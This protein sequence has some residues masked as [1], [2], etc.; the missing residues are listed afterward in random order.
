MKNFVMPG[1][2][3]TITA[4]AD[5]TSGELL[6]DGQIVGVISAD[7]KQG[8]AVAIGVEGVYELNKGVPAEA[9]LQGQP[10]EADASGNVGNAA[11][12]VVIGYAMQASPSGAP[13][14]RVKL[15]PRAA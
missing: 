8:E 9:F 1:N 11:G 5:V 13:T 4:P 3:L 10:V 14:V 12:T 6:I 2:M 7:A 15:I